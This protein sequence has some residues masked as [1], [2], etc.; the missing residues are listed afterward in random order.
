MF[1]TTPNTIPFVGRNGPDAD[2]HRPAPPG[3]GYPSGHVE[4]TGVAGWVLGSGGGSGTGDGTRTGAGGAGVEPGA[5]CVAGFAG[6]STG[7]ATG[8]AVMGASD[9]G[10][11]RHQPSGNKSATA[12]RS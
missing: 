2:S 5:G 4:G 9:N 8:F 10:S 12:A 3:V 6:V 7:V 1:R 11:G